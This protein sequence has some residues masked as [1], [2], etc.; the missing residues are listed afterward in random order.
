MYIPLSEYPD[1]PKSLYHFTVP[2][3][4]WTS[5][6]SPT[7]QIPQLPIDII[8][9][10]LGQLSSCDL[11]RTLTV[12]KLWGEVSKEFLWKSISISSPEILAKVRSAILEDTTSTGASRNIRSLAILK[13]MTFDQE[14]SSNDIAINAM[15]TSGL[16]ELT[17][18]IARVDTE[19]LKSERLAGTLC[20]E[21]SAV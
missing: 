11:L 2:L 3:K 7:S 1:Y 8:D 17:L 18:D 20:N 21:L 14:G 4:A 12:N 5:H 6:L 15:P 19:T 13:S 9:L 10:I 16:E